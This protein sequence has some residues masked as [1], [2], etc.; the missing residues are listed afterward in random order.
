[1]DVDIGIEVDAISINDK[2]NRYIVNDF[3]ILYYCTSKLSFSISYK[4]YKNASA[5][6]AKCAL[7]DIHRSSILRHISKISI[8]HV[9]Y[10]VHIEVQYLDI[11]LKFRYD[12]T[13]TQCVLHAHNACMFLIA[14]AILP[15]KNRTHPSMA[16]FLFFLKKPSHHSG[17]EYSIIFNIHIRVQKGIIFPTRVIHLPGTLQLHDNTPPRTKLVPVLY[18]FFRGSSLP[19]CADLYTSIPTN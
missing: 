13:C 3:D 7:H 5:L 9:R 14:N 10:S 8:K 12:T 15:S 16:F 19:E 18:F 4:K 17:R 2:S 11:I 1:M 6:R